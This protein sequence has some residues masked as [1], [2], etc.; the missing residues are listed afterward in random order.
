MPFTVIILSLGERA[1][2]YREW[3]GQSLVPPTIVSNE[4]GDLSY[5]EFNLEGLQKRLL[6][7]CGLFPDEYS[8]DAVR[9]ARETIASWQPLP[10]QIL[11]YEIGWH[12]SVAPNLAA[13]GVAGLEPSVSGPFKAIGVD[14]KPYVDQIVLTTKSLLDARTAS[15]PSLL[16]PSFPRRPGLNLFAPSAYADLSW[17]RPS[18]DATGDERRD[19]RQVMNLITRQ[20]G[21]SFACRTEAQQKALM[22]VAPDDLK[23]GVRPKPHFLM[24]MRQRETVLSVV[25]MELLAASEASAVIRLPNEINRTAGAV[26]QFA[27]HYRSKER[28]DRR[29]LDGFR[30][31]QRRLSEAV[32]AEF[33]DLIRDAGSDIRLVSDA[34][35]EWLDIDGLPLCIRKNVSRIATTP[36]NLFVEQMSAKPI[37]R[38]TP[39]EWKSVLVL[40]ALKPEDEIRAMFEIAFGQFGRHWKDKIEVTFKEVANEH[41]LVSALNEFEGAI[42]IFDGHGGHRP[43]EP[44]VLKLRDE[45]CDVWSLRSKITRP[46]PIMIL[47][48]CDTHAAD[49]NH[50]TTANGFLALGTRAVLGSVFPIDAPNAAAF[51]ARL[52]YRVA[53]FV[54]PAVGGFGRALTWTEVCSGMLRMQLETDLRNRL[55]R[56]R[57]L[58]EDQ[59]MEAG[60]AGNQAINMGGDDPF[61]EI[62]TAIEELGVPRGEV[63]R[64]LS[65]ATATSSAISYVQMG[66]PETILL[67]TPMRLAIAE[68]ELTAADV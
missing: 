24:Q 27:S 16:E 10:S 68:Q 57:L 67:D 23:A 45:S 49:R 58:N 34:H 12:G 46:P 8:A 30:S 54:P 11:P 6:E 15:E 7:V 52:I 31:V 55:L 21:Y 56:R 42:A 28:R 60:Y 26:R 51:A 62:I 64:Q 14:L 25:M 53:D 13:L 63:E 17:L 44:A 65:L 66:R 5:D 3:A 59:F 61:A 39:T 41:D 38:L 9:E 1:A 4:G 35:L 36:G 40:S 20:D 29:T 33:I 2:D 47:S 22:G 18:P 37:L 32:P 19:F 48:A 43:G 50:A